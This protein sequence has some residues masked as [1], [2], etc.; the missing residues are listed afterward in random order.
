MITLKIK[1]TP[2]RAQDIAEAFENQQMVT[3][4][5]N[6]T[7]DGIEVLPFIEEQGAAFLEL[8]GLLAHKIA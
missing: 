7:D 3:V 6:Y 5:F 1:C 4:E 8:V 2:A